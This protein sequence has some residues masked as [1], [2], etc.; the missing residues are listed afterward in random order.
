MELSLF[1]VVGDAAVDEIAELGETYVG[2]VAVLRGEVLE[3]AVQERPMP[4]RGLHHLTQ[5]VLQEPVLNIYIW[6]RTATSNGLQ[7]Q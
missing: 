1:H 7:S 4:L 2:P 5:R 6:E 3:H